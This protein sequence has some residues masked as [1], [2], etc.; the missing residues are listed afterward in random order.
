MHTINS[1]VNQSVWKPLDPP[2]ARRFWYY[3]GRQGDTTVFLFC[4]GRFSLSVKKRGAHYLVHG[5]TSTVTVPEKAAPVTG[6]TLTTT[7]PVPAVDSRR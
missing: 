1:R 7:G 2:C 6:T 4:V 5:V 3:V